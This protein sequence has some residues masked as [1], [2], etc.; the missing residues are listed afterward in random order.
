MRLC[1]RVRL[2]PGRRSERKRSSLWP[3][4]L[5]STSAVRRSSA[6]NLFDRGMRSLT[7]VV[8]SEPDNTPLPGTVFSPRQVQA[9]KIAVIV[10]GLL[11]V[12]G[13]VFLLA[14][15]AYQGSGGGRAGGR[16]GGPPSGGQ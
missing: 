16:K 4:W 10:M 1:T 5:S 12:G 8:A 11:L 9:L 13:F 2:K 15:I 14:A 3:S 7:M 6:E